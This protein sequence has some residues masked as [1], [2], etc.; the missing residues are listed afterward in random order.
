MVSPSASPF[1]P[2]SPRRFTA[3]PPT[4]RRLTVQN[5]SKKLSVN[6]SSSSLNSKSSSKW[7]PGVGRGVPLRHALEASFRYMVQQ[8]DRGLLEAPF[9]SKF[10]FIYKSDIIVSFLSS[11]IA[12]LKDFVRSREGPAHFKA[13]QHGTGRRKS[14]STQND[15]NDRESPTTTQAGHESPVNVGG[16]I[17]EGVNPGASS[18]TQINANN[19]AVTTVPTPLTAMSARISPGTSRMTMDGVNGGSISHLGV[20]VGTDD[21][22]CGSERQQQHHPVGLSLIGDDENG[23]PPPINVLTLDTIQIEARRSELRQIE[24]SLRASLVRLAR[25]YS[26]MVLHCSNFESTIEVS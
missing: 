8:N 20:G 14:S 12:Y 5:S 24:E 26:R 11:L 4:A 23:S 7:Q 1:M 17:S 19:I 25:S 2:E 18:S 16:G 21:D 3:H 10:T 15:R 9:P 22:E 13:G 6:A